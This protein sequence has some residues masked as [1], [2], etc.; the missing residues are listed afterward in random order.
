MYNYLLKFL[1]IILVICC[2]YSVVNISKKYHYIIPLLNCEQVPVNRL[3]INT[4]NNLDKLY[5]NDMSVFD[6]N[7]KLY[8]RYDKYTKIN[9]DNIKNIEY[10]NI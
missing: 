4:I 9:M 2:C 6:F 1:I 5:D 8:N 7:N 10:Y 3:S